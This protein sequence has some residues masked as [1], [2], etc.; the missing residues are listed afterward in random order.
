MNS[1]QHRQLVVK[2]DAELMPAVLEG[3][4][5]IA[6]EPNEILELVDA[7]DIAIQDLIAARAELA[8]LRTAHPER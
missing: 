2:W 5:H 1:A 8:R 6:V 7:L 4:T 3:R